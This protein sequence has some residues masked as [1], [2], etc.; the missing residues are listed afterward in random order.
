[1][2]LQ[3]LP[4]H[5]ELSS[6]RP[7]LFNLP[8][9]FSLTRAD[10][11]KFWPFIDN[12]YATSLT[13]DYPGQNPPYGVKYIR[14]RHKHTPRAE[15]PSASIRGPRKR[16]AISCDVQF[17]ILLFQDHVECWQL[18]DK[19]HFHTHSLDESDASKRNS[20]IKGLVRREM[21]RGHPPAEVV[22]TMRGN[23]DPS[24]RAHL[25]SAGGKYVSRQDAAN[26]G[27]AWRLA[28]PDRLEE[29]TGSRADAATQKISEALD[30]VR[31]RF[32][33]V[34]E[35]ADSLGE[36]ERGNTLSRWNSELADRT[37]PLIGQSLEEWN[38]AGPARETS[39]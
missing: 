25:D 13:R 1:M 14:C 9:P 34:A 7:I 15:R 38:H 36:P 31:A 23:G 19:P 21:S 39:S 20:V 2:A 26:T 3:G 35:Y 10:Y 27:I 24:A 12:V 22:A 5:V 11:E 32:I 30:A 33:E 18:T 37:R 17:K 29:G 6:I 28:N 8:V 16:T 4:R